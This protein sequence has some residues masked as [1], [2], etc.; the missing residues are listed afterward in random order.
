MLAHT[1]KCIQIYFKYI[2]INLDTFNTFKYIQIYFT[3]IELHWNILY[4][5]WITLKYTTNTM[6]YTINIP[7]CIKNIQILWC[8]LRCIYLPLKIHSYISI[9]I[10]IPFKYIAI[11][12]LHTCGVCQNTINILYYASIYV[13][14]VLKPLYFAPLCLVIRLSFKIVLAPNCSIKMSLHLP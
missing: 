4:K 14:I 1:L 9:Y 5:H 3:C 12:S 8:F 7:K 6:K 13:E 2:Q 10:K 11:P